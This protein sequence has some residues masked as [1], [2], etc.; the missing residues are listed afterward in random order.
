M[1]KNISYLTAILILLSLNSFGQ[2][3]KTSFIS[4]VQHQNNHTKLFVK[5]LLGGWLAHSFLAKKGCRKMY[6]VFNPREKNWVL[7]KDVYSIFRNYNNR[8]LAIFENPKRG[9]N[10]Y[11]AINKKGKWNIDCPPR[12]K[13]ILKHNVLKTL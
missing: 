9:K 3:S 11:V 13:K 7:K 1:N 5:S 12:L 4:N 2:K 6:F 10:F 8:V